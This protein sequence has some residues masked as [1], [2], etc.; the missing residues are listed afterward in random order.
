MRF[1]LLASFLVA[2]AAR[3]GTSPSKKAPLTPL[4]RGLLQPWGTPYGWG[5]DDLTDQPEVPETKTQKVKEVKRRG[6]PPH[7]KPNDADG[8]YFWNAD[9]SSYLGCCVC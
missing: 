6:K 3:R 1:L 9:P 5:L 2:V 7:F 4:Q 8:S